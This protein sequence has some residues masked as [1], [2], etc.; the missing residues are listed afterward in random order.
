MKTI[1]DASSIFSLNEVDK[2]KENDLKELPKSFAFAVSMDSF[3]EGVEFVQ[4]WIP[5]E[6]ELPEENIPVLVKMDYCFAF[7]DII[8]TDVCYLRLHRW[9]NALRNQHSNSNVIAWRPIEYK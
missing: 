7:T 6:E 3:R 9:I 4:R 2:L 1:E 5:I 8:A